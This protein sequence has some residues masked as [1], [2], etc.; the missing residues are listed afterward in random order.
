M[1]AFLLKVSGILAIL[2]LLRVIGQLPSQ[3]PKVWKVADNESFYQRRHRCCQIPGDGSAPVVADH[4]RILLAQVVN[5]SHDVA[6]QYRHGVV[7]HAFGFIAVVVP[8][9]IDGHN[10]KLAGETFHLV[11]PRVPE[12]GEPMDHDHQRP[13][14]QGGVVDL[15]AVVLRVSMLDPVEQMSVVC[16]IEPPSV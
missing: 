5:D 1:S 9:E 4:Y 10:L 14:P 8:P 13:L 6:G 7:L 11:P 2:L 3:S 12:I 15:N 16:H